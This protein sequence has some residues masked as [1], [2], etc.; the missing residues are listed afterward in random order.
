MKRNVITI[1]FGVVFSLLLCWIDILL[2]V[3][4][5]L[6][7]ADFGGGNSEQ[8]R[9]TWAFLAWTAL[10]IAL[11]TIDIITIRFVHRVQETDQSAAD[12]QE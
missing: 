7:A 3:V 9:E 5:F 8:R 1:L 2:G 4:L 6:E 10:T 11:L 12:H